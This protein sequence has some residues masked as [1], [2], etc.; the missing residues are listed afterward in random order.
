MNKHEDEEL[1]AGFADLKRSVGRS[2]KN[3]KVLAHRVEAAKSLMKK[4]QKSKLRD[5]PLPELRVLLERMAD[6]YELGNKLADDS[7]SIMKQ[8]LKK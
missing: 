4:V 3:A 7:L 5:M 6:I 8:K 2:T 1:S